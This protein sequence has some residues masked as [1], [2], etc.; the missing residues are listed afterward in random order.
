MTCASVQDVAR[1]LRIL[2][3]TTETVFSSRR[4]T[5]R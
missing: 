1:R 2:A 4:M 5:M 3:R